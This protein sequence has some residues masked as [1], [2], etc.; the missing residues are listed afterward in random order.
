M[1]RILL[2]LLAATSVLAATPASAAFMLNEDGS[3]TISSDT[4]VG[5]T[6]I[7]NLNGSSSGTPIAGLTSA[8]TLIFGGTSGNSYLFGYDL[9][10]SS[11]SPLTSASVM[12]FGFDALSPALVNASVS[13]DF[14]TVASG[15]ISNG[16][17]VDV[18][19]KNGQNNNC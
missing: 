4:V 3:L 12:G 6:Y 18:C 9:F 7:I 10:N 1:H 17:N 5:D 2:G 8:L 13:G 15:S 16:Y 11:G 19:V 14:N